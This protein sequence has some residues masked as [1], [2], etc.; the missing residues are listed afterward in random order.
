MKPLFEEALLATFLMIWLKKCVVP[1]HPREV[2]LATVAFPDVLLAT[3]RQRIALL[4]TLMGNL[5]YGLYQMVVKF[6]KGAANHK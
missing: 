3:R 5:Q 4:P 1:S 6:L 2:V